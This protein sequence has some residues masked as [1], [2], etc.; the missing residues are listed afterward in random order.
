[1]SLRRLTPILE[2]QCSLMN[3]LVQVEQRGP[4]LQVLLEHMWGEPPKADA[5]AAM[6]EAALEAAFFPPLKKVNIFTRPVR[7]DQE[8]NWLTSFSYE[9][10]G[11]VP[12]DVRSRA[13]RDFGWVRVIY[14][15]LAIATVSF[16]VLQP[17]VINLLP[18]FIAFVAGTTFTS[19]RRHLPLVWARPLLIVGGVTLVLALLLFWEGGFALPI[20]SSS[21]AIVGTYIL[22]LGWRSVRS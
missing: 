20:L 3:L 6:V 8:P 11:S 16:Y 2:R 12:E 14:F 10:P 7:T 9:P 13:R 5:V 4:V 18:T 17:L 22:G 19:V 21:I 15:C 1:M